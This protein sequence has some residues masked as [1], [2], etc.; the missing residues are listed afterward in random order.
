MP[1][2]MNGVTRHSLPNPQLTPDYEIRIHGVAIARASKTG[3]SGRDNYPWGWYL[4]VD[5][6]PGW[7]GS[8]QGMASTLRDCVD[9]VAAR[10]YQAAQVTS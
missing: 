7:K 5:N 1:N 10:W 8:G 3:V 4:L 9:I 6:P 2:Y